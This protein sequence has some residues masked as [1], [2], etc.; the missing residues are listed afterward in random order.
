MTVAYLLSD[1]FPYHKLLTSDAGPA[2]ASEYDWPKCYANDTS[3]QLYPIIVVDNRHHDKQELVRLAQ[4]IRAEPRKTFV[5]RVNDPCVFHVQDHWYQFC[6][7]HVDSDRVHFLSPYQSTGILSF[8]L[9]CSAKSRFV[10]APFTYDI[11]CEIEI[12]HAKR[13]PRVAVTGNQRRDLYP[14]RFQ[15][16]RA[17]KFRLISS[18]FGIERLIHPGYPEKIPTPLHQ[19][20]GSAYLRWLSKFRAAFTD[21]SAYRIELL[22][23]REIAYAGSAPLGDLPWSLFECPDAAFFHYR[24]LLDLFKIRSFVVDSQATQAVAMSYRNFI[25]KLRCRNFWRHQVSEA[26]AALI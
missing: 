14:L 3:F 5:L 24:S 15:L 22:K 20:T 2:I 7:E 10:Y 23:Y 25:R 17:S 9:S 19:I 8:W 1:V 21:S 18:I 4:M 6:R 26:L 12:D 13:I 11:S 16:Q